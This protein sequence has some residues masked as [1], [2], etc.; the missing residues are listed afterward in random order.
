MSSG[1]FEKFYQKIIHLQIIH[2]DTN[3]C[4]VREICVFLARKSCNMRVCVYI[5]LFPH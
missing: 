2:A 1:S 5:E 4:L 3:I